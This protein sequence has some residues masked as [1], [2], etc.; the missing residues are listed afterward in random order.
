[1]NTVSS[2]YRSFAILAV[3]SMAACSDD[4]A[5]F[6]APIV[7]AS[8]IQRLQRDE[9]PALAIRELR[10]RYADADLRRGEQLWRQCGVCHRIGPGAGNAS[11]PQLNGLFGR[12][13]GGLAGFPYSAAL[14]E[15][16]FVWTPRALDAWLRSPYRF[17]PGNR[18]SYGGLS[19]PDDRRDLI[20]WMLSRAD[21]D[22]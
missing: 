9:P 16:D 19:G 11:G 13:A 4:T 5:R 22:D 14:R 8:D 3:A 17:L 6:D 21:S 15:A 18:M 20:A 10:A 1:M 7:T 2:L 12:K